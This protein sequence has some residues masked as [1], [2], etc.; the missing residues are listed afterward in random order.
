MYSLLSITVCGSVP[1]SRVRVDDRKEQGV[2]RQRGK[3]GWCG[4]VWGLPRSPERIFE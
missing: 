2:E 4:W 1:K 3:W